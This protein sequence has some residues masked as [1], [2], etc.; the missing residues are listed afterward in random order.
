MHSKS[1]TTPHRIGCLDWKYPGRCEHVNSRRI[2]KDVCVLS[3][4]FLW[5]GCGLLFTIINHNH[6]TLSAKNSPGR[7]TPISYSSTW[8]SNSRNGRLK[9]TAVIG[10]QVCKFVWQPVYY[11]S[12]RDVAWICD[13]IGY[14]QHL[15]SN[16]FRRK[17]KEFSQNG[18]RI[19]PLKLSTLIHFKREAKL[20]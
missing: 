10:W 14:T 8:V 12:R 19:L 15:F 4:W 20:T 5:A 6:W 2:D 17:V 13:H 9:L 7:T 11:R 18:T 1:T 16:I 3:M